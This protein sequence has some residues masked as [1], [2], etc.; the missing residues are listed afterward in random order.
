MQQN[1]ILEA[2]KAYFADLH[3]AEELKDFETIKAADLIED[4]VDA[5]T[6]VMHLEDETGRDIPL[7]EVAPGFTTMTFKELASQL[8]LGAAA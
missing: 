5:V 4:S 1:Q 3:G 7:A 8:A 6:F 2:M